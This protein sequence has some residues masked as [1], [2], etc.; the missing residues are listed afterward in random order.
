[1]KTKM[2]HFVWLLAILGFVYVSSGGALTTHLHAH[3]QSE[4]QGCQHHEQHENQHDSGK[5]GDH[6]SSDCDTC[7][8]LGIMIKRI[9]VVTPSL[10]PEPSPIEFSLSYFEQ[11]VLFH[12]T[13]RF[14]LSR[15]P[16]LAVLS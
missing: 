2:R 14:F 3:H 7:Q 16:P 5:Q 12:S 1:M 8:H 10:M 6:G 4:P 13:P 11:A 9:L 15:G